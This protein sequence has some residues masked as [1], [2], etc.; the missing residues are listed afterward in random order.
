MIIDYTFED[1]KLFVSREQFNLIKKYLNEKGKLKKNERTKFLKYI[2]LPV[3]KNGTGT[4]NLEKNNNKKNN[5]NN[6]QD[7]NY[8]DFGGDG[9]Y[10]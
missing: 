6:K 10:Y 9:L 8:N 3:F 7:H 1:L 5:K 4:K 2:R